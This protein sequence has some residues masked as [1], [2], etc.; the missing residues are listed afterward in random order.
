MEPL[1][2]WLQAGGRRYAYGSLEASK[3]SSTE[4]MSYRTPCSSYADDSS[5]FR[6][7][8]PDLCLQAAKIHE[9]VSWGNLTLQPALCTATGLPHADICSGAVSSL[10]SWLG[11]QQVKKRLTCVRIGQHQAPFAHPDKDLQDLQCSA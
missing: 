11:C 5:L 10:K 7:T 2:R 4:L 8:I 1:A 3:A 6:N 9:Y